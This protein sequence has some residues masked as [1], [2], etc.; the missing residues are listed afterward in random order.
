MRFASRK[1]CRKTQQSDLKRWMLFTGVI[2]HELMHVLGFIHEQN[3]P[4]RDQ[5]VMINWDNIQ[6]G[7]KT[8]FRK[9]SKMRVTTLNVGYDYD[10]LMHYSSYEFARTMIDPL[11]HPQT[12]CNGGK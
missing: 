10:S 4:D 1:N 6:E 2:M 7:K 9:I 8:N 12:W 3:R 5:F 11:S